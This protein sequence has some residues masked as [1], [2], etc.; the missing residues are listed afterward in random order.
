MGMTTAYAPQPGTIP[1]RVIAH[2]KTLP[3]GTMVPEAVLAETL[4]V[5][6]DLK[7]VMHVAHLHGAVVREMRD[8][9]AWWG[10]DVHPQLRTLAGPPAVSADDDDIDD[11]PF[12]RRV[13]PATS[14]GGVSL[15][16]RPAWLPPKETAMPAQPPVAPP[17][18]APKPKKV[19]NAAP[20]FDPLTIEVKTARPIPPMVRGPGAVS[21]YKVL[22]N[23]LQPGQ[24]VDLPKAAAKSL[25]AAAKKAGIKIACRQLDDATTGIWK[26]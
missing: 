1:A 2:L 9:R 12:V 7:A 18:A 17:G 3:A 16:D 15:V 13:I 4:D 6:P 26:L 25:M 5:L 24:S 20:A 11:A 22:L 23:R 10:V 8:G 19:W 14:A 21:P